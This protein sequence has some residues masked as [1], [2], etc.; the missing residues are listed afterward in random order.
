M[1]ISGNK[2]KAILIS[3]IFLATFVL[4]GGACKMQTGNTLA[5]SHLEPGGQTGKAPEGMVLIPGGEFIMGSR[6]GEGDADEYP[7]HPV[8]LDAYY[9]DKY[10]VTKAQFCEF[11]NENGKRSE[12]GVSWLDV[13]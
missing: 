9:M 4:Y 2:T 1:L 6:I 11:L 3:A 7:Q 8:Y 13:E 10:E 12:G 5:A